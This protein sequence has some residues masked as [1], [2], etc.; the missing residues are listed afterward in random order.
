MAK[1]K[2][3][4]VSDFE[5]EAPATAAAATATLSAENRPIERGTDTVPT[6]APAPKAKI[7]DPWPWGFYVKHPSFGAL[8]VR[9][10]EAN[11][12]EEAIEVYRKTKCPHVKGDMLASSGLRC[13]VTKFV[14]AETERGK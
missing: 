4:L 7:A 11:S 1:G 13:T 6:P 3:E 8:R 14:P 12:E 2:T 9:R 10:D 5:D